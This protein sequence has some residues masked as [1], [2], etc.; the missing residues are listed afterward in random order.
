[1]LTALV[2]PFILF[3]V[4]LFYRRPFLLLLLWPIC[5]FINVFHPYDPVAKIGTMFF[6]PM[7][8]AYIFTLI[9]LGLCALLK[10]TKVGAI[11]KQNRFLSI[12]LG[13]VA[14]YVVVCTPIYGQSA[15]GEARKDYF[16]FLFPLMALLTIKRT[17]DL[18]RFIFLVILVAA[19]LTVIAL[20]NGLFRVL[21][22]QG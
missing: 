14:V 2:I 8:I 15:L 17:G 7:D 19:S 18:R 9:H 20:A 5:I 11:L 13:V 3:L 21:N 4:L 6:L 16:I 1:M 22:A 10:P 12:F